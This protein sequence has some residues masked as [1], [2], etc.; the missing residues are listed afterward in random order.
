[1]HNEKERK[2]DKR[3]TCGR[4]KGKWMIVMVMKRKKEDAA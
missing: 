3:Q 4:H 1:M 2:K